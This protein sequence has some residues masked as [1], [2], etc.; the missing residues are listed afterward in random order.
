MNRIYQGRVSKV[1]VFG[2]KDAEGKEQWN[3]L[4]F[5]REK[6]DQLEKEQECLRQLA[7]IENIA[8]RKQLAEITRQLNEPWQ[9]ALWGHH[10][11]FQ[12]A[13]NYYIL[14]LASLADPEHATSR[15]IKDLRDRV[16][17]AWSE[18][19]RAVGGDARSLRQSVANCLSLSDNA[20]LED[21]FESVLRGNEATPQ[22]RALALALLLDRCGG[23]SSI[24]QGGRG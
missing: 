20:S 13:V 16:R 3:L 5:T 2:G 18:F 23:E 12:D 8:A 15:L 6:L 9:T 14:A 1:E 21:A 7:N 24:Q 22:V 10:Q 11:I 19:P 4:G 17:A